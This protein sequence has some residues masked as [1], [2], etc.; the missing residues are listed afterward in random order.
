MKAEMEQLI[1]RMI[2]GGI[3]FDEA[4]EEFEKR[5][6]LKMVDRYNNNLSK[7]ALALGIHRNILSKRVELYLGGNQDPKPAAKRTARKKKTLVL[8]AGARG[9]R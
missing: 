6:I 7:A 9:I 4:R 3:L 2:S 1:D 8:R 5:F